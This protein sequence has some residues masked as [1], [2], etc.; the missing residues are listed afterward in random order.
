MRTQGRQT[1]GE[2]K[3]LYFY[4][5]HFSLC[6][7]QM[8]PHFHFILG[9][10]NHVVSHQLCIKYLDSQRVRDLSSLCNY[11]SNIILIFHL[12]FIMCVFSAE[13]SEKVQAR[14]CPNDIYLSGGQNRI[15]HNT[16]NAYFE[17]LAIF[18]KRS[19]KL[20]LHQWCYIHETH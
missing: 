9:A 4:T 12:S 10:T 1:M 5:T 2:R 16:S 3:K 7:E 17:G 13:D 18:D 20:S 6:F 14:N 19:Q 8:V 15:N 11:L